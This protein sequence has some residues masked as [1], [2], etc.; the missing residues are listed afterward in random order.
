MEF[1]PR[2]EA[3]KQTHAFIIVIPIGNCDK[4]VSNGTAFP[5]VPENLTFGNPKSAVAIFRDGVRYQCKKPLTV[6]PHQHG[7]QIFHRPGI[8]PRAEATVDNCCQLSLVAK[9]DRDLEFLVD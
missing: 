3:R 2:A 9:L 4:G 6:K 7:G 5:A 8:C 1:R